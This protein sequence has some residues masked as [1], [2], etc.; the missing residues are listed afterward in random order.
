MQNVYS[1]AHRQLGDYEHEFQTLLN[2]DL[3][4]INE[5]AKKVDVPDIIVPAGKKPEK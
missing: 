1:D 5:E 4:R 2:N 3:G